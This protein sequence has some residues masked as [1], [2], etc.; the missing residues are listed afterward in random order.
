MD[1]RIVPIDKFAVAPN[2]GAICIVL[3]SFADIIFYKNSFLQI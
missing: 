1:A 2:F 3:T